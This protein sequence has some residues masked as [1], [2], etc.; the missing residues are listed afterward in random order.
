MALEHWRYGDPAK[1]LERRGEDCTGCRHLERWVVGDRSAW[2][3]SS[4]RAPK[5]LREGAPAKRCDE[6]RHDKEDGGQ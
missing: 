2:V 3:C 6:W 1:V 5:K 4:R